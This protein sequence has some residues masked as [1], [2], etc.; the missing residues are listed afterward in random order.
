M[1]LLFLIPHVQPHI[2][3]LTIRLDISLRGSGFLRLYNIFF[4]STRPMNKDLILLI[5]IADAFVP[6]NMLSLSLLVLHALRA[7]A[8]SYV[9]FRRI[10]N[11]LRRSRNIFMS[12]VSV[13][14]RMCLR[15]YTYVYISTYIYIYIYISYVIRY[16]G[17]ARPRY[18]LISNSSP[19]SLSSY[20]S[21]T[22]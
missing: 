22:P 20:L 16:G 18:E 8:H 14:T 2:Q 3:F 19:F 10:R 21:G 13:Y 5:R 12:T 9:T 11:F 6:A 7:M 17:G 15:I 1:R 4:T